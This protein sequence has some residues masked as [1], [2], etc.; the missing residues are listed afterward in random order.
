LPT[1]ALQDEEA[2]LAKSDREI[3]L[4]QHL[5]CMVRRFTGGRACVL[6]IGRIG[7]DEIET[8]GRGIE[9]QEAKRIHLLDACP[10]AVEARGLEISPDQAGGGAVV[11]HEGGRSGS[12]AK[13]L[14]AE[15]SASRVEIQHTGIRNPLAE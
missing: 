1:F 6:E 9:F 15:G 2:L 14:D 7:K 12:P 10:L 5:V 8:P 13:S 4:G 3:R 11:F